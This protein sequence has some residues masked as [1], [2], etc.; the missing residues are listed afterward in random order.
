MYFLMFLDLMPLSWFGNIFWL[1]IPK[2]GVHR[3]R[4]KTQTSEG[5]GSNNFEFIMNEKYI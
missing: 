2:A 5:N 4:S 1:N 3:R